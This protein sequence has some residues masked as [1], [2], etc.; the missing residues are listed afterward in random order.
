MPTMYS[1]VRIA[2]HPV[3][4]MLIAF[5]VAFYTA[6]LVSFAV[7]AATLDLF[8]WRM[9]L[10]SNAAGVI[11]AV[12]AAIPGFIDWATGIPKGSPAKATGRTHMLLNVSALALFTINLLVQA[13]RWA[14]ITSAARATGELATPE[15]GLAL[16]LSLLGVALT[17]A[18]GFFGWKLVQTHHVGVDL[19]EEQRRFEP[20]LLD[21]ESARRH[22]SSVA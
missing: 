9:G 22:G 14:E 10:W 1:K 3:H 7:Y 18:A 20:S 16:V 19:N 17:G 12:I 21:R 15:P 2:G 11:T 8:W 13:N 6:T 4:P 5:P